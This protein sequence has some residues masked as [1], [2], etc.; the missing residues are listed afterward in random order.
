MASGKAL[1]G[2]FGGFGFREAGLEFAVCCG[3]KKAFWIHKERFQTFAGLNEG[4][5]KL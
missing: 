2:A 4:V 3:V 5:A 1:C